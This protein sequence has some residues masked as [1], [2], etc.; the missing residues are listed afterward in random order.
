MNIK[1]LLIPTLLACS[2]LSC[3]NPAPSKEKITIED[4]ALE[5]FLTFYGYEK[6][7]DFFGREV[8]GTLLYAYP[9]ND[10]YIV[11]F[12]IKYDEI[13]T[14]SYRW[15]PTYDSYIFDDIVL[16][17]KSNRINPFMFYRDHKFYPV[18]KAFDKGMIS[19]IDIKGFVDFF[20]KE[21]YEEQKQTA[22]EPYIES[23]II[24]DDSMMYVDKNSVEYY[25]CE[26]YKELDSST[27]YFDDCWAIKYYGC[28]NG[29]YVLNFSAYSCGPVL[30]ANYR[31]FTTSDSSIKLNGITL[32]FKNSSVPFVFKNGVAYYL[33]TAFREKLI[34]TDDLLSIKSIEEEYYDNY[35]HY[36]MDDLKQPYNG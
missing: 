4:Y 22:L 7:L 21:D 34:T 14:L 36:P 35:I 20:Y 30:W 32:T 15:D 2:L 19:Y 29:A 26:A 24:H 6:F 18:A 28:Y 9:V 11:Q 16:T 27:S 1:K 3:A 10:G 12:Y 23:E 31:G 33:S 25:A 5:D 13:Q 17:F 8:N